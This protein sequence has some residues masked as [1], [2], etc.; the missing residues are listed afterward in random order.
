MGS[1]EIGLCEDNTSDSHTDIENK[2]GDS[3]HSSTIGMVT[4]D[5]VSSGVAPADITS[6]HRTDTESSDVDNPHHRT[7]G[8]VIDNTV[9]Y[10]VGGMYTDQGNDFTERECPTDAAS[11]L[12]TN[13]ATEDGGSRLSS[14][15]VQ[16][17]NVVVSSEVETMSIDQDPVATASPPVTECCCICLERVRFPFQY[18]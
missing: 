17:A 10:G 1:T 6:V 9:S 18:L 14:S 2:D 11:D 4:D 8:T 16:M 3:L 12:G 5:T 7:I 15:N 13:I